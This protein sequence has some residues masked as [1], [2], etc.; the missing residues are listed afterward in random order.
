M[1][2]VGRRPVAGPAL[3]VGGEGEDRARGRFV[4][5][6]FGGRADGRAVG[7]RLGLQVGGLA[8]LG[9]LGIGER[10]GGQFDQLGPRP[11][12]AA[13]PLGEFAVVDLDVDLSGGV[14]FEHGAFDA[15]VLGDF[16]VQLAQTGFAAGRVGALDAGLDLGIVVRLTRG[17]FGGASAGDEPSAARSTAVGSTGDA[18]TDSPRSGSTAPD[19][20]CAGGA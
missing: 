15:E 8:A 4:G 7:V 12:S 13:E 3:G 16:R 5:V 11:P 14:E 10:A 17:P 9:L 6:D 20:A 2:E 18:S 19:S 1:F